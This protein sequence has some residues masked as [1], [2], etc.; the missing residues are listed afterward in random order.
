MKRWTDQSGHLWAY[1]LV[2]SH[3]NVPLWKRKTPGGVAYHKHL[4]TR[5]ATPGDSDEIE[6]WLDSE[7]EAPGAHAIDK[8]ISGARLASQDWR[9]L[10]RF[11]A[12]QDVRTPARLIEMLKR[13]NGQ[14][15]QVID[16]TV[17]AA[18]QELKDAHEKGT[19]LVR[20][21]DPD[22]KYFPSRVIIEHEGEEETASLRVET[23]I[24]RGMWL[25][26]IRYMLKNTAT[27]LL[28]HRW[29]ILRSAPNNEWVT[30][31]R[32]VVCLN[33]HD[34]SN[35]DFGGGWGSTGTEIFLPL[36]P[37]H[38]MYTKVGSKPPARGTVLS[39]NDTHAL[40]R[41]IVENAHRYVFAIRPDAAVEQ[42]RPRL[43]DAEI[44]RSESDQWKRWHDEQS[45][46]ERKYYAE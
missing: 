9:R 8:A 23:I 20:K 1:R 4:Y 29:S 28:R 24:G 46:V 45:A 44:F 18:A 33:Y 43:V 2:V 36:S 11:V 37:R 34:P 7:F 41:M 31:D 6:K 35:Y 40:Q 3:P 5:A 38:L 22:A 17:S 19:E 21:A 26:A 27:A 10:I 13:W 32:P 30:S 14:M 42:I 39:V 12:A 16:D 15:Q 25:Y